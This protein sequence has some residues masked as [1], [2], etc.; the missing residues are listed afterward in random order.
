M[1]L[2]ITTG[3]LL[4]AALAF[5][6]G[7]SGTNG[8]G[9]PTDRTPGQSGTPGAGVTQVNP[10]DSPTDFASLRDGLIDR[11]DAIG[12]SVGFVPDDVRDDLI[13]SCHDLDLFAD[14][15]RVDEICGA[16]GDAIERADPGLIDVVISGLRDLAEE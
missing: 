15:D 9:S 1:R 7:D 12:V 11:L 3:L 16:L 8:N 4:A 6:C 14:S 10:D 13:D 5:A 2:A